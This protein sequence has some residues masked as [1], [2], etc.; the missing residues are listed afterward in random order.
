MATKTINSFTASDGMADADELLVWDVSS[1]ETR[2]AARSALYRLPT[3]EEAG[4][5]ALTDVTAWN[6]LRVGQVADARIAA[7]ND[8]LEAS[9]SIKEER[10]VGGT[11]TG[12]TAVAQT[13]VTFLA[14]HELVAGDIV[15]IKDSD[16]DPVLNGVR[17]VVSAPSPTTIVLNVNVS[18]PGTTGTATKNPYDDNDLQILLAPGAIYKIKGEM[19]FSCKTG[20]GGGFRWNLSFPA[21]DSF[22]LKTDVFSAPSAQAGVPNFAVTTHYLN[23]LE[24]GGGTT[25]L[26]ADEGDFTAGTGVVSVL[27]IRGQIDGGVAGGLFKFQWGQWF[28]SADPTAL[29]PGSALEFTLQS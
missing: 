15:T 10:S 5:A 9:K 19:V 22:C 11:I 2:K 8:V 13:V 26:A 7:A 25:A 1:G 4:G 14:A 20:V 29:W 17:T 28:Y 6:A 3:A 27:N 23:I 18:A 16:S 12:N 21:C 24:R